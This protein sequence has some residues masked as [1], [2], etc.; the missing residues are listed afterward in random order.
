MGFF[1]S[2]D[3]ETT[4]EMPRWQRVQ[5]QKMMKEAR[6]LYDEGPLEYSDRDLTADYNPYMM[7][8]ANSLQGLDVGEGYGGFA[9]Q[10]LQNLSDSSRYAPKFD[11][12][13]FNAI[14]NNPTL[15]GTLDSYGRDIDRQTQSAI[16]QNNFSAGMSGNLGSS[17]DVGAALLAA[18]AMD[19]KSDFASGLYSNAFTNAANAG[20]TYGSQNAGN[21]M[22]AD[23]SLFAG[24]ISG[25]G[26]AA[27]IYGNNFNIGQGLYGL[28]QTAINRE[29][30]R[31]MYNVESPW[32]TLDRF[33][34]AVGTMGQYGGTT[35]TS[36]GD[37][38]GFQ[39]LVGAASALMGGSSSMGGRQSAPSSPSYQP[40]DVNMSGV[41]GSFGSI[42]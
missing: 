3:S 12:E 14:Y 21:R 42:W 15:Q 6:R 20:M 23:K 39:Q 19:A 33:R 10:G 29:V 32:N 26:T 7:Y 16:T 41:G 11:N 9:Q 17:G 27:N 37:A 40:S 25:L 24:G 31:D 8:G 36:G 4:T 5:A 34:T 13:A 28:D 35:T 30:S 2:S 18:R 1:S 38:S 22:A